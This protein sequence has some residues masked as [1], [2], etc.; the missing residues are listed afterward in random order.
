MK[1]QPIKGGKSVFDLKDPHPERKVV[2]DPEQAEIKA[3]LERSLKQT[4]PASDPVSV[5]QPTT[6]G[7]KRSTRRG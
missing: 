1:R 7:A 5:S 2:P 6:I 4:F 3:E